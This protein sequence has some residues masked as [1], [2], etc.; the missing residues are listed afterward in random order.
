MQENRERLQEMYQQEHKPPLVGHVEQLVVKTKTEDEPEQPLQQPSTTQK[1]KSVLLVEPEDQLADALQEQERWD[2]L[3]QHLG[4]GESDSRVKE[5]KASDLDLE[6]EM[7]CEAQVMSTENTQGELAS[8]TTI[9]QQMGEGDPDQRD[10]A[11]STITDQQTGEGEPDQQDLAGI[12]P[13]IELQ[14]DDYSKQYKTGPQ[15]RSDR[16]AA[17]REKQERE[18]RE[19]VKRQQEEVAAKAQQE[20]EKAKDDQI[21]NDALLKEE[22]EEAKRQLAEVCRIRRN[23]KKTATKTDADRKKK[24]RRKLDEDEEDDLEEV[25]D[26]DNDPDYDP[27]LDFEDEASISSEYPDIMEV[28]KHAHCINL[29]DAGQ[30]CVWIRDQLVELEHHVKIG[31]GVAERGYRKFVELLCDGIFK[32]QTWSPIEA[33]DVNQVMKTIIDP[34]C[35]AW[36]KK[37]K[38][39]KTGNCRQIWKQGDKKEEVLRIAEDREIPEETEEVLPEDS[40]KGKM[41]EEQRDIK[42]TIKRYFTHVRKAH[43][44]AACAAGKLTELVDVLDR[45]EFI[46]IAWAGTCPLVALEFLEVK[47][48]IEQKK[49]EVKKAEI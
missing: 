3:E 43:E 29:A 26:T 35:T 49:E 1:G 46:A 39:V 19:R 16:S 4:R 40:L 47:K 9:D 15:E 13:D 10:L 2:H 12:T 48:M 5:K 45:E 44:E 25:D 14:E 6:A 31:G 37:M 27:D 34:S 21:I 8:S 42:L 18:E 24:K 22:E 33:A 41:A 23:K 28:E 7:E 32:M 30:Y 36:K 11:S 38:G 17:R 20:A